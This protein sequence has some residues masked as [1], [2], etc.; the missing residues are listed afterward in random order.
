MR[1]ARRNILPDMVPHTV[2]YKAR[3]APAEYLFRM[4]TEGST[5]EESKIGGRGGFRFSLSRKGLLEGG[6]RTRPYRLR[7][8]CFAELQSPSSFV[9]STF[10]LRENV[11]LAGLLGAT[12]HATGPTGYGR[13]GGSRQAYS[14]GT[15]TLAGCRRHGASSTWRGSQSYSS[16]TK[17]PSELPS[18]AVAVRLE[19]LARR[20]RK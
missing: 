1:F 2:P 4:V 20:G 9:G 10:S 8:T 3:Q 16:G 12:G 11:A 15:E 6:R 17:T 18:N 13:R 5:L 7:Q 19:R 14:S